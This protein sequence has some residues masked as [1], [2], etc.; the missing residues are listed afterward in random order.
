[1]KKGK[2]YVDHRPKFSFTKTYI[3]FINNY[4]TTNYVIKN[5]RERAYV[6]HAKAPVDKCVQS[7]H[8]NVQYRKSNVVKGNTSNAFTKN[9]TTDT[10][11]PDESRKYSYRN[12]YKGKNPMTRTQWRRYQRSKKGIAAKANGKAVDPKE[13]LVEMVRRPVKERLSLPPV[14]GNADRDDEMDSDFM[15]SE[16]DFDVI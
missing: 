11:N 10:D 14:E 3:S 1:M 7:I 5:G 2:L 13:K 16:P 9:V 15:D 8:K 12:N 6:P 4:S